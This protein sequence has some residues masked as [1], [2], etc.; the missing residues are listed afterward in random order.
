M[1]GLIIQ[2]ID[3]IIWITICHPTRSK[4]G[5]IEFTSRKMKSETVLYSSEIRILL[6]FTKKIHEFENISI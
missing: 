4:F 2:P 1:N 6:Y 3:L 5:G